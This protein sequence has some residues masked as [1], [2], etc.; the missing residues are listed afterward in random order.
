MLTPGMCTRHRRAVNPY[1][2]DQAQAGMDDDDDDYNPD[3][4]DY[5]DEAEITD[6]QAAEMSRNMLKVRPTTA[7]TAL[8]HLTLLRG[9]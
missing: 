2:D 8:P 9:G 1:I 5:E 4:D 7:P 6:R 3:D